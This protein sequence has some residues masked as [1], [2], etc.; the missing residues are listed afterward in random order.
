MRSHNAEAIG[1][2]DDLP[3]TTARAGAP[4]GKPRLNISDLDLDTVSPKTADFIRF[5]EQTYGDRFVI[6]DWTD[7]VSRNIGDLASTGTGS[8]ASCAKRSPRPARWCF[9]RL[10]GY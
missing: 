5:A 2:S 8:T 3:G 9:Q 6:H 10:L 7:V 1:S 4:G